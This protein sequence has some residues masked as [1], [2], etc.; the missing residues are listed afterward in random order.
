[1]SERFSELAQECAACL[2]RILAGETLT[3]RELKTSWPREADAYPVLVAVWNNLFEPEFMR[4]DVLRATV[5]VLKGA[6]NDPAETM[7]RLEEA[8]DAT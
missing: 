6:T 3:R 4:A 2:E 7:R 8:I 5:L 1:M